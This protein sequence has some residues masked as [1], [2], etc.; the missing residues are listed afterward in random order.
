MR[1]VR[2]VGAALIARV[3]GAPDGE[4]VAGFDGEGCGGGR[5]RGEAGLGIELALV[6]PEGAAQQGEV[7]GLVDVE[8]GAVA[9]V[10]GVGGA[11]HDEGYA[12]EVERPAAL[13]E[14]EGD[15]GGGGGVAEGVEVDAG[16]DLEELGGEVVCALGEVPGCELGAVEGVALRGVNCCTVGHGGVVDGSF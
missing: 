4:A 8:D 15:G 10:A 12:A 7:F 13:V 14:A 11:G 6:P 9:V 1:G 2:G 16:C 5:E 3:G